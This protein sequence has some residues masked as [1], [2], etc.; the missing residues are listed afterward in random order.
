[1]FA[2]VYTFAKLKLFTSGVIAHVDLCTIFSLKGVT[3]SL[4]NLRLLH[5][6]TYNI[7]ML[8]P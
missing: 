8:T 2:L 4:Q 5:L 6:I 1:M 7:V 3:Y